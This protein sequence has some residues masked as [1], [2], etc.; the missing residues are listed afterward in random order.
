M[1]FIFLMALQPPSGPRPPHY[2]GFMI[3]LRH[4][5]LSTFLLDECSARRKNIYLATNYSHETDMYAPPRGIRTRNPS[6][7]QT[8]DSRLRPRVHWNRHLSKYLSQM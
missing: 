1:N 6:K 5:T 4:V 3:T 8:A 2:R 7:R